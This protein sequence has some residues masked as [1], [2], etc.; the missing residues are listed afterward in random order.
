MRLVLYKFNH[1]TVMI[2]SLLLAACSQTSTVRYSGSSVGSGASATADSTDIAEPTISYPR[3]IEIGDTAVIIHPPQVTSWENFEVIEGIAAI[4]TVPAEGEEMR[5][6]VVS[7][8]A[9]ATPDMTT[10]TVL[11]DNL[12]VTAI[13]EGSEQLPEEARDLFEDAFSNAREI[14]L[15]LALSHLADDLIPTTTP[16]VVSEPPQIFLSKNSAVL[17]LFHGEPVMAPIEGLTIQF[18]ANTNWSLFL[19]E[20]SDTWYLRNDDTWLQADEYTG[21]WT[22]ADDLPF[23]LR[24]LPDNGNWRSTKLAVTEWEGA[25]S[26]DPPTVYVST[27]PAELILL[28]GDPSLVEIVDGLSYVNNTDNQL[29]NYDDSWYYLVSGRWFTSNNLE[30]GW[31]SVSELPTAFASIPSDHVMGHVLASVPGTPE[32]K[33][34]ILDALIPTKTTLPIDTPL[35]ET[36]SYTGDPEFVPITD[37]NLLRAANTDFDVIQSGDVFYLCYNGTWYVADSARGPW[38]LTMMIPA[39]IY[40]IPPSDPAYKVTYVTVEE[41]TSSTVTYSYNSGYSNVYFYFGLAVWGSGWYYPPYN[42]YYGGYPYYYSYPYSYGSGSF[43]NPATGVYGSVGRAYGPYGGYGYSS[44]LN[45]NTGTYA[46]AES[47]WNYDEWYGVGEAY[48]PDSGNY[49]GTERYYDADDEDWRVNSS[50]QTQRGDIDISRRFDETGGTATV[51]TGAGGEGTFTRR[52]SDGGWDTSGQFSTV[53]GRTVSTSGRYQDGRGTTNF[54]GS[55]GGTGTLERTGNIRNASTQGTFTRDG[56]TLTTNTTRN[57]LNT[58]TRLETS[59]GAQAVVGG[60]GLE[61]RSGVGRTASGDVYATRDGNVY[62]RSD[63]GWEQRSSGQWSTMETTR[64]GSSN[65]SALNDRLNQR[66]STQRSSIVNRNQ[67]LNRQYQAR[68]RGM[69]RSSQFSQ[70]QSRSRGSSFGGFRRR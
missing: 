32:A 42:Y 58:R 62:R 70:F 47:V 48:N 53:D 3:E 68:Q 25:P 26:F 28:V 20:S 34:A 67:N 55:A 54:I 1:L 7:F 61:S 27:E 65:T 11:V 9:D 60:T 24:Q 21:P 44:G 37:T 36:V 8:S 30:S 56:Q 59:G 10:R 29:F 45:P 22:W 49:F 40:S 66:S 16:N 17:M 13:S 57:G 14:P 31:Q 52:A 41:S 23:S 35:P 2:I 64:V 50:L 63:S 33:I 38:S 51:R 6:G 4:E 69:N 19:D 5:Y 39:E 43:Y 18:A 12:Q 15:D 46:R